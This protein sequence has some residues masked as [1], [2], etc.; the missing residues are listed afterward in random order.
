M[1]YDYCIQ[2]PMQAIELKFN[3]IFG[4]DSNL[5]TSLNRSH[6]H[7]LIRKYSHIAKVKNQGFI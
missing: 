7:P 2:H 1:T 5:I 6:F 4:K 3:M